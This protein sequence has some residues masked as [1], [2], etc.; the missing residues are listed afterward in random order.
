M[1]HVRSSR[2]F[3]GAAGTMSTVPPSCRRRTSW[4]GQKGGDGVGAVT[5]HTQ[6]GEKNPALIPAV[7]VDNERYNLNDQL[8]L[9]VTRKSSA[10]ALR[11]PLVGHPD[12]P[13]EDH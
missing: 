1:I 13:H 2:P 6:S 4:H 12:A 5:T 8:G 11:A 7:A 10:R 3:F 9:V